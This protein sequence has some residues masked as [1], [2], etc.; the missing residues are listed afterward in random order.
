MTIKIG[1]DEIILWLRKNGKAAAKDTDT[2]GRIILT[3][4][5]GLGGNKIIDDHPSFWGSSGTN[6]GS[7]GLPK[8]A[9]QYEIDVSQLP[10]LYTSLMDL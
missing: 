7:T 9:A 5:S 2:L 6:T 10:A 8:T 4:M 3:L 1:A